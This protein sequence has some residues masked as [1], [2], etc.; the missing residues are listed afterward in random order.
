MLSLQKLSHFRQYLLL[1]NEFL[2]QGKKIN[3][4]NDQYKLGRVVKT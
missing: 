2:L 4:I 3:T 1:L